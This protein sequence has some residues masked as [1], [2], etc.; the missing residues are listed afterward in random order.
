M[1]AVSKHDFRFG[2]Q[3]TRVCV[4]SGLLPDVGRLVR[5]LGGF[6]RALV[7]SDDVVTGLYAEPVRAALVGAGIAA[8][9]AVVPAGEASKSV[10]STL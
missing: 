3:T 6:A 5:E 10:P 2:R 9:L 7:V 1:P 8:D 4:G